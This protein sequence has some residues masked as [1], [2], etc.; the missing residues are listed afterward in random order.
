MPR[1]AK[2]R[3]KLL[4]AAIDAVRENGFSATSVDDLCRRAGVTKGAFFHHFPTKEALGTAAA[5]HWSD[6]TGAL[7][8]TAPYHVP[9]DPL[10]RVLAY[11]EFRK[12]IIEGDLAQ[13]SCYLGTTVQEAYG[14]P[15][16]RDACRAGIALHAET[17]E[18]D[19]AAAADLYPPD[20]PLDPAGLALHFQAVI[21]GAFVLAKAWDDPATARASLDHLISYVTLLFPRP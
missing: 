18:A 21:Q 5:H 3:T 9:D 2:A 7:F 13:L 16:L 14:T 8:H 20:T 19:I 12:S 10:D 15:G 6:V 17:L 1:P 4:D 11:L